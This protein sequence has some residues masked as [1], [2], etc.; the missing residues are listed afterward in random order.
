M[1][2]IIGT[3]LLL[4]AAQG[5]IAQTAAPGADPH[6][7]VP[8]T[9]TVAPKLPAEIHNGILIVSKT[10]SWR[11]IEHIPH[12]NAVLSGIAKELG[13]PTFVTENAAVFSDALLKRFSVIVLNSTNGMFLTPDQGAALERFV[14]RGGGLVA[15]HAAG[16]SSFKND[17]YDS[18]LMGGVKFI[19][20]P[21]GSDQ[22][23]NA[24][25]TLN[26]PKHPILA[27]V[28]IPWSPRD[29][30]YSFSGDPAK[31]GMTVLASID[32]A[33]YKPGKIAMGASHPVIW[34]NARTKGRVVYSALGHDP[35]AYDDPNY[36][37]ILT[38]AIRWAAAKP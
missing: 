30:W 11:H 24:K 34:I 38:N 8:V 14:A 10:S 15:L 9:D 28:T 19:G 33:S 20:H 18:T 25:I 32:E 6:R 22:F 7:P 31:A 21:G 23:Q 27:G 35:Q 37:R 4:S 26:D 36:R 1:L 29:E 16:D 5:A 2:R 12:S 13:R 17:W 3:A